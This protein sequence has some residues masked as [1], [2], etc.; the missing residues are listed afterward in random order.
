MF[1]CMLCFEPCPMASIVITDAMP[2]I[3]PNAVSDD[4]VLFA[5]IARNAIFNKFVQFI[6][7]HILTYF[8]LLLLFSCYDA[9]PV[10]GATAP[11]PH[12]PPPPLSFYDAVPV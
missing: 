9:V 11:A 12:Q 1:D 2:M 7:C 8:F 5:A 10:Q 3:M 6:Y 4:R